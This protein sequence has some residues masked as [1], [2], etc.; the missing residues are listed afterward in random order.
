[1]ASNGGA[2]A[3]DN[4]GFVWSNNF[5]ALSDDCGATG[6]ATVTFRATD[7]CG[8]FSESTATFTI[9]DTT[10]PT[11]TPATSDVSVAC[12]GI[13]NTAELA[14]WLNSNGGATAVD[15][16]S[17][18]T[19]SNDF[20]GFVGNC[21]TVTVMF[22]AT[23]ACNN[24]SSTTSSFTILPLAITVNC[25]GN[26]IA[27]DCE[28]V[29]AN[30]F[31]T[32]LSSFNYS[33]G[34]GTLSATDLSGYAF[35][36]PGQSLTITYAVTDACSQEVSC[37][38]TFTT[39][40][41][42]D[43]CTLGYWKNQP[44][45]WCPAYTPTTVYGSVFTAAPSQLSGLTFMEV[46]NIG[47]GGIFNLGRQSVAALLNICHVEV[48]YSSPYLENEALLISDVNAAFIA[49]GSAPGTLG[50]TLDLLN[51]VGCSIDAHG[52][53]I[54]PKETIVNPVKTIEEV[55]LFTVY[56]VP[57]KDNIA[58]KYV[59]DYKSV[60]TIEI[61]DYMGSLIY[62]FVDTKAFLNKEVNISM[63][64][65]GMKGLFYIVRVSTDREMS[66]HKI[67]KSSN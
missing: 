45:N 33:G 49:G 18:V 27:T 28:T 65:P 57:F 39:P 8:N 51:Q 21:G 31:A 36:A 50:S 25:P 40:V 22:T 24:F 9:E 43:G 60:V 67:V 62:R 2:T 14:S 10:N 46:L 19:W 53:A 32:W 66:S 54:S 30:E 3:T 1:M 6:S 47:G 55:S 13:G 48:D 29:G 59:F 26:F 64:F 63:N 35:P 11:I 16:C 34:C 5:T 23:D 4:C 42:Y 7:A 17:G 38:A 20:N 56:P 61:F 52:N 15:E 37:T 58:V 44:E 41:C 12:D